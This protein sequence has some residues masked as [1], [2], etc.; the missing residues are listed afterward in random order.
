[1]VGRVCARMGAGG[2][3][4][5]RASWLLDTGVDSVPAVRRRARGSEG[6]GG[7]G[8]ALMVEAP[9]LAAWAVQDGRSLRQS[10]TPS[11]RHSW[12]V[13]ADTRWSR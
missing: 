7:G 12:L 11:P 3:L 6:S 13:L 4:G 10:V 5:A 1:M 9:G 8:A 2:G